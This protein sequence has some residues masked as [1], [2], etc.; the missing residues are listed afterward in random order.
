VR[1][2]RDALAATG[3][4][5]WYDENELT[6]GDAWD[7]KIR[8]QIRECDY[9][10]PII[11]ANTERRR[12]GYFRRE[13]RLAVERT[14]DMADDVMFLLPVSIDDTAESHA[15]VP[16]KFLSVQWLRAPGGAATP[17]LHAVAH[18]L[19]IGHH[20]A[21][22]RPR[23]ST[24]ATAPA[25][26]AEPPPL[27]APAPPPTSPPVAPAA[28][29]EHPDGPPPM[30]AFPK[31]HGQDL[32]GVLK[33]LAEVIWWVVTAIWLLLRRAPRWMRL[34]IVLW[35]VLSFIS[36]CAREPAPEAPRQKKSAAPTPAPEPITTE[37]TRM[38]PAELQAHLQ[39][40]KQALQES[41]LPTA[42]AQF[43][44]AMAN[45]LGEEIKLSAAT[46]KQLVAVPFAATSTD[47]PDTA[48]LRAVFDA[49]WQRVAADRAAES[50]LITTPLATP[51]DAA[52]VALGQRLGATF[53]LGARLVTSPAA[54]SDAAETKT[55]QIS[56]LH[57]ADGTV[58]WSG[59]FPLVAAEAA[60]LG[61]RVATEVLRAVPAK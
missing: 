46:G 38:T 52:L 48:T 54:N 31:Q 36:Y 41:G 60:G 40:A 47:S 6:G 19:A 55:L 5:V 12:E 58:A 51:S 28:A 3:L 11:S 1:Q 7:A 16:E 49:C 34:L 23:S 8:R 13:W 24:H 20:P 44:T 33:F 18:R 45:R 37:T 10:M 59:E 32:G 4:E 61:E 39:E 42:W 30:P 57:V 2:L 14:L 35:A 43:G 9:F 15:R 25:F 22:I 26:T 50:A 53:I 56:L 29:V 21:P 27:A 17:A